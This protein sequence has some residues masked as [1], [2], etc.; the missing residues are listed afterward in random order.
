[1]KRTL[2]LLA[3]MLLL[4][5]PA[6]ARGAT[7]RIADSTGDDHGDGSVRYPLRGN[8]QTGELDLTGFAAYAVEGGTEFE[9]AL[10]RQIRKPDSQVIDFGGSNLT[11]V[12]RWG[13]Y[14]FNVDV[15]IDTDGK[16]GSGALNALPERNAEI[17]PEN[18]WER[19]VILTPRPP[20]ARSALR[21]YLLRDI[22]RDKKEAGERLGE[23]RIEALRKEIAEEVETRV[24]FPTRITVRGNKIRFFVPDEFLGGPASADWSYVVAISVANIDGRLDLRGSMGDVGLR[25]DT[26]FVVPLCLSA[27]D[28]CLGGGHEGE[29][30]LQTPFVDILVPEGRTQEQV[31]RSYDLKS[32]ALVK[33]PGVKP[34]KPK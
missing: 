14:T 9:V 28:E 3:S 1:M 32:D 17:A 31:L 20:E 6:A 29:L 8:F 19:A 24:F 11:D 33:L 15:Y 12:A 4:A 21:R 13:F 25:G 27:S 22:K 18:A 2:T 34:G 26:L 30:D 5:T 16:P 23:A 7:F 10:A